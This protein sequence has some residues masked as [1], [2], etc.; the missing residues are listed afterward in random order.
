MTSRKPCINVNTA[1]YSGKE[2]SPLHYGLSAEGYELDTIMEGYDKLMWITK[3]KNNR[4]VWIRYSVPNR[5]AHEPQE[6]EDYEANKTEQQEIVKEKETKETKITEEKQEIPIV[7]C[8]PTEKNVMKP[9]VEEKKLTAYN[10][11]LTYRLQEL[12]KHYS[13]MNVT[14]SNKEVFTEVVKQWKALD[15]K[16]EEYTSIMKAAEDYSKFTKS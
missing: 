12:K 7:M 5:M 9:V 10:M 6:K 11:F 1:T 15:K 8:M 16:S 2:L 3:I 13:T 14:K 4:K